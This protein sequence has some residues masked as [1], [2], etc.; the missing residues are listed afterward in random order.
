LQ[1]YKKKAGEINELK[2][3]LAESI[4]QNSISMGK[5]LDLE[6]QLKQ[7]VEQ[8][9]KYVSMVATLQNQVTD[10]KISSEEFQ[11]EITGLKEKLD[12]HR[13]RIEHLN[14]IKETLQSE[15]EALEKERSEHSLSKV[16]SPSEAP[17]RVSGLDSEF[18]HDAVSQENKEL[19][20]K[21]GQLE[22]ENRRLTAKSGNDNE[23]QE[24]IR[25]GE[26]KAKE[27][28]IKQLQE[29][30]KQQQDQLTKLK[31]THRDEKKKLESEKNNK[32]G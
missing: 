22:S 14:H 13:D 7:A 30:L 27:E 8:K 10:L 23:L 9:S 3:K 28:K 24:A 6:D 4:D 12:E 31:D 16:L 1:T 29:Q 11:T 21:V 15:K 26:S 25:A 32:R 20:R 18:L 2:I 5:I 17:S 19:K